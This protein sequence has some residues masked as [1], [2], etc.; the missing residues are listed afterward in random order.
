M[1]F[2]ICAREFLL[3]EEGKPETFQNFFRAQLVH[4]KTSAIIAH[5]NEHFAGERQPLFNE[6]LR[7]QQAD[8]VLHSLNMSFA[9]YNFTGGSVVEDVLLGQS[10]AQTGDPYTFLH[11]IEKYS[12]R[13]KFNEEGCEQLLVYNSGISTF[14]PHLIPYEFLKPLKYV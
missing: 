10:D 9:R 14:E 7:R 5:F 3:V 4:K 13:S 6:R 2:E 11:L 8:N 1:A 12:F